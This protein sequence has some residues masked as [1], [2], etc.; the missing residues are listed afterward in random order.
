MMNKNAKS[1]SNTPIR[2]HFMLGLEE[3]E[4]DNDILSSESSD[5][6][7]DDDLDKGITQKSSR[8]RGKVLKKKKKRT[9]L[10]KS[11]ALK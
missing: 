5:S 7:L 10:I 1:L 6:D 9:N 4:L 11:K 2:D 3:I 8:K